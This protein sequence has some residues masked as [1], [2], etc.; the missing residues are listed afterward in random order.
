MNQVKD[1]QQ[2]LRLGMRC[3]ASGVSIV[4]GLSDDGER[5]AMTASSV[6]SVSSEPPSLL[7]CV[8]RLA[9]MTDVLNN[10]S[11]FCINILSAEQKNVSEA[12]ATPELGEERFAVGNWNQHSPTGLYYLSDSPAVFVCEKQQAVD[13]GTHTIYIANISDVYVASGKQTLLVY[14]DGAYH[15]L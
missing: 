1:L 6:T 11:Q 13:H 10:S 4:S 12:C 9:R 3:L 14:A 15:Y 7:V 5:C 8:N 2:G